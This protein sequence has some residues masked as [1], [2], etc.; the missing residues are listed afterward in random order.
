MLSRTIGKV[1]VSLVAIT[2]LG[3]S[4][5]RSQQPDC[6]LSCYSCGGTWAYEGRNF[7]QL[8]IYNMDCIPFVYG[9][10]GCDPELVSDLS[11]NAAVLAPLLRSGSA[12]VLTDLVRKNRDRLLIS[13]RRNLVV[14][15]GTPCDP[16]ALSNIIFVDKPTA[17]ALT[18]L[19]VKTLEGYIATLAGAK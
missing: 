1:A 9:C 8:G 3:F 2:A 6:G 7:S 18:N 4:S 17:M 5:A 12:Q 13:T 10:L 19:G 11:P 15:R 14:I 16:Q